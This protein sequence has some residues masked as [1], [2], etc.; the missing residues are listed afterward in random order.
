[1]PLPITLVLDLDQGTLSIH[2]DGTNEG[3]MMEGLAGEYCW[4]A[5]TGSRG[6]YVSIEDDGIIDETLFI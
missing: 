2:R 4:F 1:M 5:T 6:D 3:V